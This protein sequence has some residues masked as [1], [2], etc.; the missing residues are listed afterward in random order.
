LGRS[1]SPCRRGVV[2][3]VWF[4]LLESSGTFGHLPA[5][6]RAPKLSFSR[7]ASAVTCQAVCPKLPFL[8]STQRRGAPSRPTE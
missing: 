1:Y 3:V 2:F 8:R 6:T 5:P 7:P 4:A